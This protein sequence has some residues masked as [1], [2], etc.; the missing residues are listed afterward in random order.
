MKLIP[1][2]QTSGD[3]VAVNPVYVRKVIAS[4]PEVTL[5]RFDRDDVVEVAETFIKVVA[6]L[7]VQ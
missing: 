3:M 7:T 4:E 2:K 1:F 5:I 6:A